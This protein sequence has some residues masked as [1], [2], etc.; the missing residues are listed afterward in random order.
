MLATAVGCAAL[1]TLALLDGQ[2][3][4]RLT[5]SAALEPAG[6]VTF[7]VSQQSVA[8]PEAWSSRAFDP[9]W[10]DRPGGIPA[11]VAMLALKQTAEAH[12]GF[13]EV[14]TVGGGTRI[15]MTVSAGV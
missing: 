15:A 8:V 6:H 4:A 12:G 3:D 7:A 5:I 2:K 1:A 14:T 9:Q 10:V 11:A 13:A